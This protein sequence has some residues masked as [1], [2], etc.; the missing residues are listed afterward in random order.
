MVA[1]GVVACMHGCSWGGCVVAPGG[2][3]WLLLGGGACVVAPGE[4][5]CV[6]YN[7]IRRYD[8]SAGGTYPIGM[9]S[10]LILLSLPGQYAIGNNDTD[11]FML[12]SQLFF[13]M[14]SMVTSFTIRT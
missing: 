4:G 2:C 11:I 14:G 8:Q 9:H 5:A 10:C 12:S 13:E 1:L 6:G 3:A 7:E